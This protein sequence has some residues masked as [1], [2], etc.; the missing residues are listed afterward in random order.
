MQKQKECHDSRADSAAI[1]IDIPP[2]ILR[3]T[4]ESIAFDAGLSVVD[5]S[6]AITVIRVESHNRTLESKEVWACAVRRS[7]SLDARQELYIR[8]AGVCQ[9]RIPRSRPRRLRNESWKYLLCI[10]GSGRGSCEFGTPWERD[11]TE[12]FSIRALAVCTGLQ[13][14]IK[15]TP[16]RKG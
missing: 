12:P 13:R 7:A 14:G 3:R 8:V 1:T 15:V 11:R 5:V 10:T 6:H 16:T 2:P 4:R 9:I